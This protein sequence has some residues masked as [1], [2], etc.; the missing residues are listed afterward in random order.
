MKLLLSML[1]MTALSYP[2]LAS[3]LICQ[4][5]INL[6][7]TSKQQVSLQLAE[8]I[9]FAADSDY[10]FIIKRK[11]MSRYCLEIF[12]PGQEVRY[13]SCGDLTQSGENLEWAIW[14]R[15]EMVEANC[16]LL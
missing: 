16:S 15:Q 10:S 11:T 4:T 8:S 7:L 12:N 3:D 6:E 9:R 5:K 13:Y 14:S 1:T 2:L